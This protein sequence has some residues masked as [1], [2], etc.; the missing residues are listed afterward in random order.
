MSI[1]IRE[2]EI[3]KSC[4]VCPFRALGTCYFD[5]DISKALEE[6]T[7]ADDCSIEDAGTIEE[8]QQSVNH[9]KT[10]CEALETVVRHLQQMIKEMY[11]ERND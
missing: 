10:R 5:Y 8:L 4:W 3:P 9:Y 1:L 6:D 7:R 2:M 11:D